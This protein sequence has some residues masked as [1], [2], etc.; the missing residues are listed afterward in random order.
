[1][2]KYA[3]ALS[4]ATLVCISNDVPPTFWTEG[5]PVA[6]AGG[7]VSGGGKGGGEGGGEGGGDGGGGA[8]TVWSVALSLAFPN[9]RVTDRVV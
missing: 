4:F 2:T 1:M 8:D 3:A 5:Y 9:R 6:Q 7:M